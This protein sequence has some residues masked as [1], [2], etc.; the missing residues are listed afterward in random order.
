MRKLISNLNKLLKIATIIVFIQS[1][2]AKVNNIDGFTINGKIDGVKNGQVVLA[3]LDLVTN[4]R[5]D[6][7]ST[8]IRDG[9][10]AFK[11][12]IESPYLHTLFF[13]NN[14]DKFHFFLENSEITITG[15]INDIENSKTI[16]SR[17][18]SLFHS[19][20]VDDIFDRKLGMEIMLNY[21]DYCF[22]A[23][24]AYYQFQ[25]HNIQSDTMDII[26]NGF[27]EPVKNSVYYEHLNNLYNTLRKVAISQPA[28]SFSVPD[29][30]GKIVKL[31]HFM[32][33]Y[34]L[35]DFW[36]SWCGPCRAANPKL[37]E[38]YNQ[39]SD[40]SF[41]IIGISVDKNENLWKRAIESDK[42]P[43][44]NLSNLKGWDIVTENYGVKAVPQN[45]LLD[46]NGIIIGKNIEPENLIDKLAKLLAD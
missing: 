9:K 42:L 19:Y 5:V 15:D 4:E 43:W 38:V 32:G 3:K 26:M 36:A 27:K 41:T 17:E 11:G 40:K 24:T 37:I 31:D 28:P 18:D 45:F 2:N 20:K 13:N 1:C 46:T 23:F 34:V 44:I 22:S 25:I 14:Q 12:K 39:F 10:F 21:S 16:G 7:D 29:T 35:I 33:K 6:V 30:A 8:E